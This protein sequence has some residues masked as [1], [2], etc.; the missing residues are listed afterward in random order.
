MSEH[1]GVTGQVLV[2]RFQD[3]VVCGAGRQRRVLVRELTRT[4]PDQVAAG[5]R[6]QVKPALDR[7]LVDIVVE[8]DPD[9]RGRRDI[10]CATDRRV[11]DD[12]RR[13]TSARADRAQ[14]EESDDERSG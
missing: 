5:R 10:D 11:V 12:L 6:L 1:R 2:S 13:V 7:L 4:Q 3:H 9:R 8:R 14:Y